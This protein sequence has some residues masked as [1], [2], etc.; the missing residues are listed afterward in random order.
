M[1]ILLNELTCLRAEVASRSPQPPS[2]ST[3]HNSSS[4]TQQPPPS[5]PQ[6]SSSLTP[7]PSLSPSQQASSPASSSPDSHERTRNSRSQDTERIAGLYAAY[8]DFGD[9]VENAL[10]SYQPLLCK[11]GVSWSKFG[12]LLRG[13]QGQM[14][15]RIL[16][17]I[18]RAVAVVEKTEVE[19]KRGTAFE[20]ETEV[21][22]PGSESRDQKCKCVR[23]LIEFYGMRNDACD[24]NPFKMNPTQR[25]K[26]CQE[27]EQNLQEGNYQFGCDEYELAV[28][29]ALEE[30]FRENFLV[31]DSGKIHVRLADGSRGP[32]IDNSA[33]A[34]N[35]RIPGMD[36]RVYMDDIPL[37]LPPENPNTHFI[38][39]DDILP[40]L[41]DL[42]D[43]EDLE[44]LHDTMP[45]PMNDDHSHQKANAQ[46]NAESSGSSS[47]HAM[48][49]MNGEGDGVMNGELSGSSSG[50]TMSAVTLLPR[51]LKRTSR[52]PFNS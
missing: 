6:K 12:R 15:K 16:D 51:S 48:W 32:V 46:S 44:D 17:A 3:A 34:P 1:Q 39:L 26:Y 13:S 9:L 35:R 38:D 8:R 42:E 24:Y 40:P 45:P 5:T 21:T 31:S 19:L 41:L 52:K 30:Y 25:W 27:T 36:H 23:G 47:G 2:S 22:E 10:R 7:Q 28:L 4:S 11:E 29:G 20:G 49:G 33:V 18:E 14:R 37:N 43:L 50:P